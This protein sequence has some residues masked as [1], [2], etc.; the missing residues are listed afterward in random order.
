MAEPAPAKKETANPPIN[1][2][3]TGAPVPLNS[4]SAL[5]GQVYF[6]NLPPTAVNIWTWDNAGALANVFT[7]QTNNNL[8]CKLGSNGPFTFNSSVSLND[9]I[10]FQ[11]NS[12]P[13][14]EHEPGHGAPA[15]S[16]GKG[17]IKITSM[18]R[19]EDK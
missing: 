17:T 16:G 6:D 15:L 13:P 1:L 11:A 19:T 5:S 12:N 18:D 8:P 4:T 14:S 10:T 3:I 2:A 7:G 9:T